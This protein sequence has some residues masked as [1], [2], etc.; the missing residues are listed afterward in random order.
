MEARDSQFQQ[1][2]QIAIIGTGLLGGSI[3]LG[4]KAAG[5]K[6]KILGIGR[7]LETL[8]QAKEMGCVDEIAT[9]AVSGAAGVPGV[10][11]C[12]LVILASPVATFDEWFTRLV[13]ECH[14]NI[15]ITD[16]G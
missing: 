14:P 7:R 10:R 1:V 5:F 6:G 16:V 9:G 15:V 12:Q 13:P 11:Q 2:R 4:L 3:G 8:E